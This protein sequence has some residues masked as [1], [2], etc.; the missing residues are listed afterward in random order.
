MKTP[1]EL[2]P[3]LEPLSALQKLISHFGERGII[4]GGIAAS[5][6]GK[7]RLTADI[8]ALILLRTEEIHELISVA[9]GE[10]LTTRIDNAAEFARKNRVL[11][12]THQA[13]MTNIDI[14]LGLL[15][16]EEEAVA[17][18]LVF[19]ASG[20]SIRLPTPEDLI[21]FKAVAHRQKDLMDIESIIESHPDLDQE[22]IENWVKQF[23]D[24]LDMPEIWDDLADLLM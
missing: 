5:L 2:S 7:P 22:R 19:D 18:S 23:A 13:S 9:Q 10:G 3:L 24:A 12:L 6:L 20:I 21:I 4:I 1:D 11:L 17:R 8:D 15:P 16:F 14:S